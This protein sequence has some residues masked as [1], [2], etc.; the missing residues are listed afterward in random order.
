MKWI[1]PPEH[2][3][4]LVR[5]YLRS[6]RAFSRRI[7][8]TVKYDDNITINGEPVTVRAELKEGDELSIHFPDEVRG[9]MLH[10]V[11]KPLEILFENEAV[12]V[13]N[14][15]AELATIPSI[16]HLDDSLSNRL[17]AYYDENDIASTAHIVTRLDVDTSGIVLIA[18]NQLSHSILGQKQEE[19]KIHR[20]YVA[21][22]EGLLKEKKGT[23]QN[24][25]GRK[26]GSI[27]EREV[28]PEGKK[29]ITHFEVLA[30]AEDRSLVEITLETGRTHQI[31]VHF[32][33]IGHPLMGDELYGGSKDVM[34]RQALHC[35]SIT[36]PDPF[37]SNILSF[38]A[39]LPEDMVNHV[40]NNI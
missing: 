9:P 5:D 40:P 29:A 11:H 19:R 14:K 18:K 24:P 35:K 28:H 27:I 22:V 30:E 23:I 10:P 32:S 39:D 2:S 4:M 31:R 20:T 34:K 36:F 25:I 15:P 38:E 6:V 17:I 1:I 8:K 16:H 37:D 26:A 3:G 21:L 33:Y 12:I 13:V 7:I